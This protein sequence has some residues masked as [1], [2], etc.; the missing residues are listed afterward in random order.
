[1]IFHGPVYIRPRK[2]EF[3]VF[4]IRMRAYEKASGIV[5]G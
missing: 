4:M 3:F 2:A 1:M 5:P